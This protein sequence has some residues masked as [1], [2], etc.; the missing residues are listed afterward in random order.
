MSEPA[1][2]PA[3]RVTV[4]LLAHGAELLPV[5][6]AVCVLGVLAGAAYL[7]FLTGARIIA[8]GWIWREFLRGLRARSRAR[9]RSPSGG[10]GGRGG[11]S[12]EY[13]AVMQ[14]AGWRRRRQ[15]AI[16]RAGRRC[17]ECGAG[18]PLDVHHLTYAHLGDERPGELVAVCEG[19]H[20]RLHGR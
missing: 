3:Y 4:W 9:S 20:G 8:A 10:A 6:L 13:Q 1:Q 16:R 15:D 7:W 17:Q 11:H 2:H 14:S 19:C 18:G 5:A 12:V